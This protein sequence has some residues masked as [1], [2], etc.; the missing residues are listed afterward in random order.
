MRWLVAF[1]VWLPACEFPRPLD[2][3]ADGSPAT[4]ATQVAD[5]GAPPDAAA[6]YGS[7][8]QVCFFSVL[9]APVLPVTLNDDIDTDSVTVC[10]QHNFQAKQYCIVSAAGLSVPATK[11]IR[12]YGSKPLI[13]LS[14]TAVNISGNIDISS[15]VNTPLLHPT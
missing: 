11:T 9:D 2:V 5:G 1:L 10:D 4:D 15:T 8:V 3:S 6:C 13:L 14:T 7:F 12:A